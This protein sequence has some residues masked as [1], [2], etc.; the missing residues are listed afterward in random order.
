M[1]TGEELLLGKRS[2]M[3][4]FGNPSGSAPRIWISAAVGWDFTGGS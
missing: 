2:K 4:F 3:P 1:D